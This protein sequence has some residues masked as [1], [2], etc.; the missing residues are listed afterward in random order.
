MSDTK[1]P[2]VKS[3][4][5]KKGTRKAGSDGDMK[6]EVVVPKQSGTSTP[7]AKTPSRGGGF[8]NLGSKLDDK[9]DDD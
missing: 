9:E 7:P 6:K 5:E 8:M 4:P 2:A 1:K 3:E